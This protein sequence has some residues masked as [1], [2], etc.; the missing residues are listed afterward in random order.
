M[1]CII[2]VSLICC[3]TLWAFIVPTEFTLEQGRTLILPT[4]FTEFKWL[5]RKPRSG[6]LVAREPKDALSL[7]FAYGLQNGDMETKISLIRQVLGVDEVQ[8]TEIQD[9]QGSIGTN[10]P[11]SI[12]SPS[13]E[14]RY[15][16]IWSLRREVY[17]TTIFLLIG[18]EDERFFTHVNTLYDVVADYREAA[19]KPELENEVTTLSVLVSIAVVLINALVIAVGFRMLIKSREL[20]PT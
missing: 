12:S 19:F 6:V 7:C 18:P 17:G 8:V 9:S 3:S 10:L 15:I 16:G 4:K 11:V 2:Y 20:K 5:D 14:C 13:L 1:C